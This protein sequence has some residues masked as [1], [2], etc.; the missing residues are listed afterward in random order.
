MGSRRGRRGAGGSTGRGS[1]SELAEAWREAFGGARAAAGAGGQEALEQVLQGLLGSE[2]TA[3]AER[4]GGH[5]VLRGALGVR[6]PGAGYQRWRRPRREGDPWFMWYYF[7]V[8]DESTRTHWASAI[9]GVY[10]S[11]A[12]P[13]CANGGAYLTLLEVPPPGSGA[14]VRTYAERFPENWLSVSEAQ[15]W[16]EVRNPD[17]PPNEG[18]SSDAKAQ[19]YIRTSPE[20]QHLRLQ[21]FFSG[22]AQYFWRSTGGGTAQMMWDLEFDRIFGWYGQS[23]LEWGAHLVGVLQWDTYMH[24]ARVTGRIRGPQGAAK[25]VG[26]D[27]VRGYGDSNWGVQMLHPPPGATDWSNYPWGWYVAGARLEG[28][29]EEVSLCAGVG[30]T[31]V[32]PVTGVLQAKF[33]DVRVGGRVALEAVFVAAEKYGFRG[34]LSNHG[35]LGRHHVDA[36]DVARGAWSEVAGT[37]LP[38]QQNLTVSGGFGELRADFEAPPGCYMLLPFPSPDGSN[39]LD[40]ECL[41]AKVRAV[42]RPRPGSDLAAAL[43]GAREFAFETEFGGLEF[44]LR[45]PG[46]LL[47]P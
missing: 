18:R 13:K 23:Q 35:G 1:A 3:S 46:A 16:L 24:R 22:E 37:S 6:D 19:A 38:L 17:V 31:Y 7:W 26:G 34:G 28:T 2:P 30:R 42:L 36:F 39:F 8:H 40:F 21:V 14:E 45:G 20:G 12:E 47:A 29:G 43:G 9:V 33:L 15:Q 25:P 5:H 10:C 41:G 32:D 27:A 44:G 4:L 11:A